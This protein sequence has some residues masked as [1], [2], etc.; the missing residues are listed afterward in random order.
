MSTEKY[1]RA[2]PDAVIAAHIAEAALP[3]DSGPVVNGLALRR[4]LGRREWYVPEPFGCCGWQVDGLASGHRARILVTGDHQ[5]DA[6]RDT[7]WVHASISRVDGV[8]EYADLTRLHQA[9]YGN[10][11]AY[12]VFAPPADHVNIHPN[13]LHL[14]GR[15]DGAR[16]LPNFGRHGTI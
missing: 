5:S 15:L 7:Q 12:Q 9:V 6:A 16:A 10:G 14:F 13:A 2:L 3:C 4:V 1:T 11:W 8:P